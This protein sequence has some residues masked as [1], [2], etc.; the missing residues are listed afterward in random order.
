MKII[1]G[2][3]IYNKEEVQTKTQVAQVTTYVCPA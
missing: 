3:H 2:M 1:D